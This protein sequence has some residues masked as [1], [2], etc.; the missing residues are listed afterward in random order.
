MSVSEKDE[1]TFIYMSFQQGIPIMFF[2]MA[3][4]RQKNL[5]ANM[6]EILK[7]GAQVSETTWKKLHLPM[8]F[9]CYEQEEYL[10]RYAKRNYSILAETQEKE[11]LRTKIM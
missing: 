2:S 4:Y 9:F 6:K 10:E 8:L 7:K 5:N 1:T 11:W 3:E